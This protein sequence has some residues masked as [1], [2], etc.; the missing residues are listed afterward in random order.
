MRPLRKGV[1]YGRTPVSLLGIPGDDWGEPGILGEG[2]GVP[3]PSL[4]LSFSY[5]LLQEVEMTP[6]PADLRGILKV[7]VVY[8]PIVFCLIW[9]IVICLFNYRRCSSPFRPLESL[10]SQPSLAR[11]SWRST[12]RSVVDSQILPYRSPYRYRNY[13]SGSHASSMWRW[14]RRFPAGWAYCVRDTVV[15]WFF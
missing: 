4:I 1:D 3:L 8:F 6:P 11:L 5:V 14:F 9:I 2:C 12:G 7:Q 15:Y 13:R 10:L